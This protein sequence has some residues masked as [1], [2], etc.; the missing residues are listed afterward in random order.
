MHEVYAGLDVSG[1]QTHSCLVGGAAEVPWRARPTPIGLGIA[2]ESP[3]GYSERR[4]RRSSGP[5][6]VGGRSK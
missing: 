3:N 1:K 6:R 2:I 4:E 5:C